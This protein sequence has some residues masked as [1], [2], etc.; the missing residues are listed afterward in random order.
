M[1]DLTKY[2]SY[3]KDHS[4]IAWPIKHEI[5][6]TKHGK[7][8][9]TFSIKA[10]YVVDTDDGKAWREMW[11]KHHTSLRRLERKLKREER[12]QNKAQLNQIDVD[13]GIHVRDEL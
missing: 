7:K 3:A 6:D 8:D 1:L 4:V 2:S 9:I 11:N 12:R 5:P 13:S 10:F